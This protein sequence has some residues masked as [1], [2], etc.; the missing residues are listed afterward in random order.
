VYS[1]QTTCDTYGHAGVDERTKV[2]YSS[3]GIKTPTLTPC[4]ANLMAMPDIRNSID[5]SAG[6]IKDFIDHMKYNSPGHSCGVTISALE[7]NVSGGSSNHSNLNK[8]SM[9]SPTWLS[10]KT[11]T[12]VSRNIQD[13]QNHRS[14][15]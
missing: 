3:G 11:G 4:T 12:T 15:Y 1:R 2:Q 6:A 13:C 7:S 8:V 10:S 9:S 5:Q 14:K